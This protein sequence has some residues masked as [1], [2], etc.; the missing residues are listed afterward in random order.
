MGGST[1]LPLRFRNR[2]NAIEP[3]SWSTLWPSSWPSF[4]YLFSFW[5]FSSWSLTLNWILL[6]SWDYHSLVPPTRWFKT[7]G[8]YYLTVLE[9]RNSKSVCQQGHVPSETWRRIFLCLLLA[10]VVCWQSLAFL[11]LQLHHSSSCLYHN[12]V[13]SACVSVSM[14][15]FCSF[16]DDTRHVGCTAQLAPAWSYLDSLHLQWSYFQ[17]KLHA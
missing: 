4:L 10:S 16:Y 5:M 11:G 12:V 3:F 9:A 17:K 13:L 7:T 2:D 6:F 1:Q 15:L 14:C 8:L